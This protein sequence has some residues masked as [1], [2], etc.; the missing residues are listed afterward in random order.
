MKGR[1]YWS[2]HASGLKTGSILGRLQG[3]QG[4]LGG[5]CFASVPDVL[6]YHYC[7][8]GKEASHTSLSMRHRGNA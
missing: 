8:S 6:N 7:D 2:K 3:G 1:T 5:S 4:N